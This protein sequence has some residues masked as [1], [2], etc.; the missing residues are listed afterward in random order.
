[1]T[2][3]NLELTK[4]STEKIQA[5]TDKYKELL[6]IEKDSNNNIRN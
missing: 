1:M 6:R 5:E 4:K 2:T 3:S